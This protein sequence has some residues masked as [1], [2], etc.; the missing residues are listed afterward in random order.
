MP[1]GFFFSF[2]YPV[3]FVFLIMV[4]V[5]VYMRPYPSSTAN[6]VESVLFITTT[7]M[8]LISFQDLFEVSFINGAKDC[9]GQNEYTPVSTIFIAALYFM[10]LISGLLLVSIFTFRYDCR[11]IM[12]LITAFHL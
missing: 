8:Y 11:V 10:P 1:S 5:V 3:F 6:N 4:G 9:S 7:I 2:Q 12:Q